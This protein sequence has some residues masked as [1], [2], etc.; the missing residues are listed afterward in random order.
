VVARISR[1]CPVHDEVRARAIERL[2]ALDTTLQCCWEYS[3]PVSIGKNNILASCFEVILETFD[4]I[5]HSM[6][7][8]ASQ[9]YVKLF[10]LI[11]LAPFDDQ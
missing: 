7:S 10:P 6:L 1:P 3:E 9:C 2:R 4:H 8:L 11:P 5:R